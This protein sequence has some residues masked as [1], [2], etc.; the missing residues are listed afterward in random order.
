MTT[1]PLR[2]CIDVSAAVH[3]RAGLGRYTQELVASLAKVGLENSRSALS[4][5]QGFSEDSLAEETGSINTPLAKV[6]LEN[7]RSTLNPSQGFSAV[8]LAKGTRSI[9]T[10]SIQPSQGIALSVFYHQRGE[11]IL[12]PP[13]DQLPQL[14]TRLSVRPWR[15]RTALAYFTNIEMDRI[16]GSADVFHAT[17]HLLPRLKHIRS[18]FTLHDLIFQFDPASHKP[19]NIAFLKTMMPRFLKH[20]DAIIAVSES[21]K[22][23][24]IRLYGVPESKLHVIYEGVDPKFEPISVPQRLSD[25]RR[26]YNLPDRF[27]LHLGTIEPRKNLPLLFEAIKDSDKHL[28]VAGKLGWLTDPILAKVKELGLEDRVH[29]TG[30]I[31]DEDLPALISCASLVAMPSKY[32]GFGLPVLEAMAC[33]IPVISSNTSS[34]PEVGG[35]AAM[36]AAP[37]DIRAWVELIDR[38][39]DDEELRASMIDRGLQQAEKFRWSEAARQT[40]EIY[41]SISNSKSSV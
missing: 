6:G 28:V 37:D 32:E 23:D 30:F 1:N 22:R 12:E 13:I 40:A 3:K 11:A 25:V 19:L 27:S 5:S 41:Q 9:D 15:L 39:M 7:S 4:P 38:A 10:S 21:T 18:V 36:Y 34:L 2:V 33:G 8:N 35:D 31:D 29:F 20:A 24:A 14:T 17:E 16:F 26:K